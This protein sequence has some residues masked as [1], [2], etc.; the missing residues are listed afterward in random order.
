MKPPARIPPTRIKVQSLLLIEDTPSLQVIYRTV[1]QSAGHVVRVASTA[2]EG[3]VAFAEQPARVVL[4]DLGLPDRDGLE[5]IR[6]ILTLRAETRIIVITA[7][8]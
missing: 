7:N 2:A 1:L 8:A 3:M 4:L 6:D 5:L